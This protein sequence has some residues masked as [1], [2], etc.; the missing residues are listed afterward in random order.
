MG[1]YP[2]NPLYLQYLP[3]TII[4]PSCSHWKPALD[5]T[6]SA[7]LS[8]GCWFFSDPHLCIYAEGMVNDHLVP[9]YYFYSIFSSFSVDFPSFECHVIY[10]FTTTHLVT[11]IYQSL[12]LKDFPSLLKEFYSWP[13][14]SQSNAIITLGDFIILTGDPSYTAASQFLD[15]FLQ[16][17]C[18][19]PD[20]SHIF[21]P[22][23][24]PKPSYHQKTF[25]NPKLMCPIKW[26][27]SP[28][29]QLNSSS[30]LTPTVFKSW[31]HLHLWLLLFLLYFIHGIFSLPSPDSLNFM[32]N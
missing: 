6:T 20:C 21:P 19:P 28:I 14:A 25:H 27:A 15:L 2:Q 23:G 32:F 13:V 26:S 9:H 31:W 4:S 7:T 8:S 5:M 12:V 30:V 11:I 1:N 16:W 10:L 3:W 24:N 29:F 22:E 18:L 17:F